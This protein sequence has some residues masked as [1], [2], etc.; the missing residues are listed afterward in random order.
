MIVMPRRRPEKSKHLKEFMA[1]GSYSLAGRISDES[2]RVTGRRVLE[3]IT[4][5]ME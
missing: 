3:I 5:R 2:P 1:I 4:A